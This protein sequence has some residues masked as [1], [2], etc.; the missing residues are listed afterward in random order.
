MDITDS[1]CHCCICEVSAGAQQ[2]FEYMA[3]GLKQGEWTFGSWNRR[4]LEERLFVGTSMFDGT[5]TY[6]R[7]D[8]DPERLMIYYHL[9]PDPNFLP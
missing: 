9:G 4:Q 7:I 5:E 1:H 2:A 3:D 6:I 8:P